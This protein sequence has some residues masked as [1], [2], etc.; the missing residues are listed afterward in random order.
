MD[1]PHPNLLANRAIA[2]AA[3]VMTTRFADASFAFVAGS[4]MRGQGTT[5]SDIDMVVVFSHL[6][7]A[8]RESFIE[9]GFPVEAFVNDP[10]SLAHFFARDSAAG[11]PVLADMVAEGRIVGSDVRTAQAW[12]DKVRAL[13]NAGP[14]PFA[15]QNL[16]YQVTDLVDDLAGTRPDAEIRAIAAQLHPKLVDLMLLG[17][18]HWTGAGKW[19]QRRLVALDAR[20]GQALDAAMIAA[21]AGD[22]AGLMALA[23]A[24]LDRH[25]G[26][27]FE[28]YRQE[29]PP[30][31]RGG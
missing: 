19:A 1:H 9:D 13:I 10:D 21:F 26:R 12:R 16:L 8:W 22:C 2:A 31:V 5:R 17:R 3:S 28:G 7:H 15:D 18:Q 23:H 30:L 29:A 4:I 14:A 20:L 24:E 25:G 27:C 6:P 11:R